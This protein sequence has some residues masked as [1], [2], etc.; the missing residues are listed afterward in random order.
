MRPTRPAAF[1]D[2]DGTINEDIE[3]VGRPEAVRLLPG[4]ARAVA[5]LNAAD[6]PVV[7]ISNQSG[8][9]RGY[10]TVAD[11][12][13]VAARLGELLAA[14]GAALDATYMC[15]HHPT[16]TGPCGCRKPGTEL[17]RRAAADLGLDL[18]RSLYVGDRWHDAAPADVL[19]GRGVLVAGGTTPAAERERALAEGRIAGT[20]SEAVDAWLR[21]GMPL[22]PPRARP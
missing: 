9:A 1:L 2:R 20:L 21:D 6:V 19:G 17:H 13:R 12:D 16:I 7:V 3:Y 14:E 18:A 8:I 22:T 10:F 4:A 5:R 11:Y 15:P